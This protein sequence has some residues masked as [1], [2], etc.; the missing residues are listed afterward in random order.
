MAAISRI[1]SK[2]LSRSLIIPA[3]PTA[4]GLGGAGLQNGYMARP[5][6]MTARYQRC[7]AVCKMVS[8]CLRSDS[9]IGTNH[10]VAR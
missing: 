3:I 7:A 4:Y 9:L 8:V 6:Q 5:V 2:L 10:E 1:V